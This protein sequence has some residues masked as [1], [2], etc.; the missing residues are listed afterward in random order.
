[1]VTG[2][3]AYWDA[4]QNL[5]PGVNSSSDELSIAL[6]ADGLRLLLDSDRPGGEGGRDLYQSLWTGSAFAPPTSLGPEVNT[7]G[8]EQG[9]SLSPDG[10][11]LVY[12]DPGWNL[13]LSTWTGSAWSAGVPLGAPVSTLAHEWAARFDGPDRLIFT[14]TE[15]DGGSGGHDLFEAER[16]LGEWS[17]PQLLL[18]TAAHEYAASV[19]GDSLFLAVSGDIHVSYRDGEGW[20]VPVPV[21]GLVNTTTG[22]ETSPVLAPDGLSL[23]F[24]SDRNAGEG[25]YDVWVSAWQP[26]IIGVPGADTP[27]SAAILARPNPFTSHVTLEIQGGERVRVSIYDIAGRRVRDLG[28]GSSVLHWDGRDASGRL[29]PPGTY[30]VRLSDGRRLRQSQ[31]LLRHR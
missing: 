16:A 12:A 7:P 20:T 30:L 14:A 6:S 13:R 24:V 4:P 23:Y 27:Q 3:R 5:G 8:H 28:A 17:D 22:Y 19:H 10:T 1:M 9:P 15:R 21:N 18:G 11:E 26:G 2:A 31:K 29:V 25:G